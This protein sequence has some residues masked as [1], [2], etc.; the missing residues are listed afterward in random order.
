M[1]SWRC[2]SVQCLRVTRL[3]LF[4]IWSHQWVWAAR[5][6]DGHQRHRPEHAEYVKEPDTT[7]D[8][9]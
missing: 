2:H 4:S 1:D 5:V 8:A 7:G 3:S 6:D 9:A